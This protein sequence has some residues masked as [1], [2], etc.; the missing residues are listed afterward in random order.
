ME[1][2]DPPV[3]DRL[4]EWTGERCVPWLGRLEVVYEHLHRYAFASRLAEGREVLDLGCGEGYG[5]CILAQ[6]ARRV[7]GVEIDPA[8]VLHARANYR[9]PNAE[10]VE[11]SA[12]DLRE[13]RDGSQGLVVCFEV[14][15]HLAE[16]QRV[17]DEVRRVLGKGGMFVVSTPDRQVYR[18]DQERNPFHVR[19]LDQQ[20]FRDFLH[21]RFEHVAVWG[22]VSGAS[23]LILPLGGDAGVLETST[24]AFPGGVA[25][26]VAGPPA[27]AYLVAIASD[28]PIPISGAASLLADPEALEHVRISDMRM[29]GELEARTRDVE[30]LARRHRAALDEIERM[31]STRGWRL[32]VRARHLRDRLAARGPG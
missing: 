1:R 20:E 28:R 8:A 10:F 6:R 3:P 5:T 14:I 22:Q 23:S 24:A 21:S 15:E 29:R 12:L 31:M 2:A 25:E 4:I 7:T 32:L 27:P 11:G 17:L 19:E 16:Q 18:R 9:L 13:F 26:V 30:R